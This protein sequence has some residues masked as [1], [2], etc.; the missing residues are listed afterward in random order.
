MVSGRLWCTCTINSSPRRW[1]GPAREISRAPQCAGCAH[2]VN[3]LPGL[4]SGRSRVFAGA[5]TL[6][7]L[8]SKAKGPRSGQGRTHRRCNVCVVPV[9]R[10]KR[11]ETRNRPPP[12]ASCTTTPMLLV[13]LSRCCWCVCPRCP[14]V[15][16][17]RFLLYFLYVLTI[18]WCKVLWLRVAVFLVRPSRL[19]RVLPALPACLFLVR[20]P[21][22][23]FSCTPSR[24]AS[25]LV[26]PRPKRSG[27]GCENGRI[28]RGEA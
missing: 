12:Y 7:A 3:V 10:E 19:P 21:A 1:Q 2:T 5:N 8:R 22:E 20:P 27:D 26:Q 6:R 11:G 25:F 9:P 13:R 15:Y 14:V 17:V 4:V 16:L 28:G 23:P 18:S 24:P